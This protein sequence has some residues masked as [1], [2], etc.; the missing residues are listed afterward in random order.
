VSNQ[1]AAA[2]LRAIPNRHARAK[3]RH[4]LQKMR[5]QWH[6]PRSRKRRHLVR[7]HEER[8]RDLPRQDI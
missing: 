2:Y 5:A 7:D 6:V 1:K 8:Q 3:I 4:Q